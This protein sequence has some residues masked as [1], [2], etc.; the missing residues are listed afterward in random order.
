MLTQHTHSDDD[1][2]GDVRGYDSVHLPHVHAEPALLRVRLWAADRRAPDDRLNGKQAPGTR[3]DA[4]DKIVYILTQKT[5]VQHGVPGPDTCR[6]RPGMFDLRDVRFQDFGSRIHPGRA[7][8]RL[9]ALGHKRPR[10]QHDP[11][12]PRARDDISGG[13]ECPGR[14][15]GRWCCLGP[16]GKHPVASAICLADVCHCG[17][18]PEHCTGR[19]DR[20]RYR[21]HPGCVIGCG[22]LSFLRKL[23]WS[24]LDGGPVGFFWFEHELSIS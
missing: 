12:E 5:D 8:L 4:T 24:S 13:S 21:T 6:H 22:M 3:T 9:P 18:V 23:T 7:V 19:V 17:S 20:T 1:V 2:H 11:G 16:V 14:G 10:C 15:G